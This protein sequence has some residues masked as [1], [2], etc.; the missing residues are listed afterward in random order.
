LKNNV[1]IHEDG[2]IIEI[3]E[4]VTDAKKKS[5]DKAKDG[6]NKSPKKKEKTKLVACGK[7]EG[8]QKKACKKC[9]ACKRK[10]R[11]MLRACSSVKRVVFV[12]SEKTPGHVEK[13]DSDE[14]SDH[15][16]P[17]A[18]P[19]GTPRIRLRVLLGNKSSSSK[20]R[21]LTPHQEANENESEI[22]GAKVTSSRKRA[23]LS[24]GRRS[25]RSPVPTEQS[26]EESDDYDEMFDV[27][28]IEAAYKKLNGA[29]F[30]DARNNFVLRGPWRLPKALESNESSF[31]EVAK[32]TLINIS[33]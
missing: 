31:K 6:A 26:D 21:K 32:I 8:C 10:K 27:P 7:C 18:E 15:E 1:F 3:H 2:S 17:P 33:R 16:T 24:N 9:D 11:C 22:V 28:K 20:K 12:P 29:S 30:I 5:G 14:G 25:A 19:K 4:D 13:D 23:R